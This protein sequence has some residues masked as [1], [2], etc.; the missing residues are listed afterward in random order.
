M[1]TP[2]INYYLEVAAASLSTA[3]MGAS[4]NLLNGGMLVEVMV[5]VV[6]E[7]IKRRP[8]RLDCCLPTPQH[9]PNQ[10]LLFVAF[11][12]YPPGPIWAGRCKVFFNFFFVFKS[13][14]PLY[15]TQLS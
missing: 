10:S 13:W 11:F 6:G 1:G 9:Q 2:V 15:P 5:A 7:V 12:A 8:F 14:A 3:G 4:C